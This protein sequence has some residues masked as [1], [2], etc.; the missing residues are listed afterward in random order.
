MSSC[1]NFKNIYND[2]VRPAIWEGAYNEYRFFKQ[3]SIVYLFSLRE[4]LF[5]ATVF[6]NYKQ[7]LLWNK[8]FEIFT[9]T[10]WYYMTIQFNFS[11]NYS[12]RNGSS[13]NICFGITVWDWIGRWFLWRCD[14]RSP[15]HITMFYYW[16]KNIGC[17]ET[18]ICSF[19]ILTVFIYF[20]KFFLI[21]S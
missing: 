14:T 10:G 7:C 19:P 21:G 12:N 2:A 3:D 16:S 1:I 20:E 4:Y 5:L 11:S 18:K 15:H 13:N 17:F 9:T 8:C 6:W